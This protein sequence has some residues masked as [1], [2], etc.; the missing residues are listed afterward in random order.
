MASE[1]LFDSDDETAGRRKWRC[2]PKVGGLNMCQEMRARARKGGRGGGR[3][4]GGF[5]AMGRMVGGR[6]GGKGRARNF[7]NVPMAP[8]KS[9]TRP[10]RRVRPG[11]GGQGSGPPPGG[12][13]RGMRGTCACPAR[14][15]IEPLGSQINVQNATPQRQLAAPLPVRTGLDAPATPPRQQ[16]PRPGRLPCRGRACHGG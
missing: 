3:G 8:E 5:G 14:F 7:S 12:R 16:L 15:R 11:G 13:R 1:G 10:K 4:R 2:F 9:G 6:F